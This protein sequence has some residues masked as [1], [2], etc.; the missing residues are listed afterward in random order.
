FYT[1]TSYP[2]VQ[3]SGEELGRTLNDELDDLIDANGRYAFEV[4]GPNGF[5][6]EFH[7]NLH[8]AA[9]MARPEVS[10][11]YQRNGNLQLNIL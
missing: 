10:V 2:V 8:L 11:T 4:H 6:R 3:E 7:G 1:V 5:F 9:Q